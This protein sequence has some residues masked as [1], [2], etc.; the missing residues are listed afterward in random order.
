MIAVS[1]ETFKATRDMSS[2]LGVH[3]MQY[4]SVEESFM[5]IP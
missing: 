3:V 2:A 5:I 1:Q 4:Y